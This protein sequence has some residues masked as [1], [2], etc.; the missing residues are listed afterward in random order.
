MQAM[1]CECGHMEQG[2]SDNDV[3]TKMQSH[4]HNEHPDRASDHKKMLHEA[5]KSLKEV[6]M[7]GG[8]IQ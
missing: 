4:I 2:G 1:T 3:A 6:A 7:A 8:E 5:K